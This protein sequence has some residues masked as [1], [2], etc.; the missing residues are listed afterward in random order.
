MN[1]KVLIIG[2]IIV[3]AGAV[4]YLVLINQSSPLA[5]L[6][7]PPPVVTNSI[8]P[9]N[10]ISDTN[11]IETTN[12]KVFLNRA[13]WSIKYPN[14]WKI[15]SC[16]SCSDPT[17][18][19]VFVDFF[20]PTKNSDDGWVQISHVA[21]KP[22]NKSVDE[23]LTDLKHTL[24]LNPILKEEKIT[25]NNLPALKVR[26]RNLYAGGKE[27]EGVYI[28]SGSETFE[29]SFGGN[30][31]GIMLENFGNYSIYT[32]MLSTFKVNP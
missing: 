21:D 25:I 20:P 5:K 18:P 14:D 1:K 24:N 32:K 17:D 11:S 9:E 23:W 6:P 22:S 3:F 26:Y 4:G 10:K 31:P 12:W 28:V 13:G 15:S 27:S 7:T 19:N 8:Q 16:H 2:L 29:I 30:K